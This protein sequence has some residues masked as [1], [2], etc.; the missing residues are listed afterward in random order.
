MGRVWEKA[1]EGQEAL[2]SSGHP[3]GFQFEGYLDAGV[4]V[5]DQL[6]IMMLQVA[7][8]TVITVVL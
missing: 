6:P 1:E 7:A 4:T 5:D 8:M 2:V 3:V